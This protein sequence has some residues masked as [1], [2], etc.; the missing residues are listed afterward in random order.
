MSNEHEDPQVS[1]AWVLRVAEKATARYGDAQADDYGVPVAAL[2]RAYA[3]ALDTAVYGGVYMRAAAL[4]HTLG[5]L[6]WLERGNFAVAIAVTSGFL[7]LHGVPS[8]PGKD[9]VR[10]LHAHLQHSACTAESISVLLRSWP[11]V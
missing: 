2:A 8:R 11:P 3:R 10:E 9:D 7:D 5:R 1:L 6:R 4:C